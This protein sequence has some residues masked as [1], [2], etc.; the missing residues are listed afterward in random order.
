MR[1]AH[2]SIRRAKAKATESIDNSGVE[3]TVDPLEVAA[4]KHAWK[5]MLADIDDTFRDAEAKAAVSR[6]PF[7][8]Y[9]LY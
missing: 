6:H 1:P 7:I 2:K 8:H 5:Y 4:E 9:S 3:D